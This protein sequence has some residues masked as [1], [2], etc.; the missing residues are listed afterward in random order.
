VKLPAGAVALGYDG[1]I[2]DV[3]LEDGR[4]AFI[5]LE[6]E[7]YVQEGVDHVVQLDHD[8]GACAVDNQGS[9]WCW[10]PRTHKDI[11]VRGTG[12]IGTPTRVDGIANAV[13]VGVGMGHACAR[14]AD[15]S[16][17]C[18]GANDKGQCGIGELSEQV[19]TPRTVVQPASG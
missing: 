8:G 7:P 6:F 5:D 11:P 3:L 16:V 9:V 19:E 2:F 15:G 14:I 10:H 18:W 17:R 12:G 4:V 13:E 1:T